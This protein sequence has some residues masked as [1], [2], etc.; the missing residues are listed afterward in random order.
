MQVRLRLR[1]GLRSVAAYGDNVVGWPG[2]NHTFNHLRGSDRV[3]LALYNGEGILLCSLKLITFLQ[4]MAQV[5][6]QMGDGDMVFGDE[7]DVLSVRT[8]IGL[9]S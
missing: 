4:D 7:E 5:A 3:E 8:S 9:V 1:N 2:N 6:F